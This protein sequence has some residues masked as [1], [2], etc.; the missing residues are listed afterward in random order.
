MTLPAGSGVT[1][2]DP[3]VQ[4]AGRT[5][6]SARKRVVRLVAVAA[7]WGAAAI[8]AWITT[9]HS[10]EE[11][12]ERDLE[13]ALATIL[14]T[15]D[16]A[17]TSW[18]QAGQAGAL[19]WAQSEAVIDL[20]RRLI[21]GPRT[22]Q[23]LQSAPAQKE[24]RQLLAPVLSTT[25]YLGYFLVGPDDV[26]LASSRDQN[27]GARSLLADQSEFMEAIRSGATA[28]SVP[29]RSDVP[30]PGP[31]GWVRVDLPTMFVGAPVRDDHGEVIA[32]FTFRID[33][34]E[35]FTELLRRGRLG[36]TG[37]TYAFDREGGLLSASRFEA[38]LRSINLLREGQSSI[39]NVLVR[40]PGRGLRQASRDGIADS[41]T[42]PLT[43]MAAS[44][45][46]GEDGVDLLGYRDYRGV[47]VV[48]AWTW[49]DRLGLG[50]T[51]E[52]DKLEAY[53]SLRSNLRA[54]DTLYA[55]VL[56]L[57]V[58]GTVA[59]VRSTIRGGSLNRRLE[60]RSN[61]LAESVEFNERIF[62][63]SPIGLSL[64]RMDGR[65]LKV[66]PAVAHI[67]GRDVGETVQ[68][69][70]WDITPTKYEN[71][72]Q[73][74]LE[75]LERSGSYGPYEKEYI[76]KD[77]HLVPVRLSGM[78][79]EQGGE[80]LIWSYVEDIS[81]RVRAENIGRS[82]AIA[83]EIAHIGHWDWD[84]KAN[85]V[86][87]SDEIYRILRL[88]P[89][90]FEPTYDRFLEHV[91]AEDR[92]LVQGAFQEALESQSTYRVEHRL[93]PTDGEV[94][95]VREV[96][97]AEYG[98]DGE[99]LR[100]A[101]TVQ[102][103]TEQRKTQERERSFAR[104]LEDSLNEIYLFD[105]ETLRFLQVNRGARENLG[106]SMQELGQLGPCDIEPEIAEEDFRQLV[107]PLLAGE[108]EV[109]FET[110]H[111]RKDGTRYPVE[112]HLQR[113]S[114]EGA[115]A[116]VAII[117]DI[118]ER[119][120]AEYEQ[121]MLL[122]E[123][124]ARNTEMERFTYTVS[125]DLKSPLITIHGFIGLLEQG[126]E[127]GDR[128]RAV[129]DM[130]QIKDAARQMK[131]LLDD[132]L[133]LSR[134]GRIVDDPFPVDL[135]ELTRD[136]VQLL[137]GR[138]SQRGIE[139]EVADDLPVVQG[140]R[141]RLHQVMQNLIDNAAKFMGD[142]PDPRIEVGVR[143]GDSHATVFVRDNGV[144]IDPEYHE[145]VFGLFD[146]LDDEGEGTGIGLALVRKIV[147]VHGG[148]IWVESDGVGTGST[149]AFTL[150]AADVEHANN[151]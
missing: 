97:R 32:V 125:H 86:Y 44:A 6:I 13:T 39:L 127:A 110:L 130:A 106:Y 108:E 79:V 37:E 22:S 69:T 61:A 92:E 91:H 121:T 85:D 151:E 101:G 148:E 89:Q 99:P 146:R 75:S 30:L 120:E 145:K 56:A 53:A 83:Q 73:L 84:I 50:L 1:P 33:P 123:L 141:P 26:N 137:Q 93:A 66:N 140:D 55:L 16:Q 45:T 72:E 142:Q 70:Y 103:I 4:E 82:L 150:P 124:Q 52:Q 78:L 105:A 62:R 149:F 133:E 102:D 19:V 111:E 27:L 132:L 42:W 41:A 80:S 2:L 18:S 65:L 24:L 129:E 49:H 15:T 25:G 144:G 114:Y 116:F 100:M 107:R 7:V 54:L 76:H 14:R 46:R 95:F 64:C 68:L 23:A 118:T 113:T 87:W 3:R 35:D 5:T 60:E 8:T 147:E 77:G 126:L 117:R 20:T 57:L 43:R 21:A 12:A 10:L 74:A 71:D 81:D 47:P 11:N 98:E 17:L 138:T 128:S 112:A 115:H 119:R 28:M 109:Q 34:Q 94:R 59:V 29:Q 88:E 63:T 9:R 36:D 104:I 31:G 67:L 40:D 38:E 58:G 135:G 90:E 48:G 122:S 139:V 143:E 136:V 131:D 51:V 134:I 96:G